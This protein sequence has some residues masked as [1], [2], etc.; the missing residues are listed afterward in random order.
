M[1]F[2]VIVTP[3]AQTGI[4]QSFLYIRQHGPLNAARWLR[5]LYATVATLERMPE[6]C[7]PAIE[8]DYVDQDLRQLI[9]KSHRIVFRI[10]KPLKIVWVLW[11]RHGKQQA[12]GEQLSEDDG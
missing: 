10:D 6:R 9:F 5:G 8:R 12:I 2:R 1:K 11:V 4:R 7:G 3:E